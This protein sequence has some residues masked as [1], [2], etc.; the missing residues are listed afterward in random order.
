MSASVSISPVL[1]I[2]APSAD[3]DSGSSGSAQPAIPAAALSVALQ[4]KAPSLVA[5]A[6]KVRQSPC[7]V[8]D[9]ESEHLAAYSS[10]LK[11]SSTACHTEQ[12]YIVQ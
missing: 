1:A 8:C 11:T 2:P 10:R 5:I 12:S 9:T 4:L 3:S 6:S 7:I